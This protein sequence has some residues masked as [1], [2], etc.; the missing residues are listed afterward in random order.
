MRGGALKEKS[1]HLVVE[2]SDG[3][4][5]AG[6][7]VIA[8]TGPTI[9]GSTVDRIGDFEAKGVYYAATELEARSVRGSPVVVVGGGNSAGQAAVFLADKGSLASRS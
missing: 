6:R 4:E 9:G 3:T 1:G 2:L 5:V 7:A 8:A